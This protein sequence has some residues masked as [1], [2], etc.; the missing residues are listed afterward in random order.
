MKITNLTKR[1]SIAFGLAVALSTALVG[2]E[3]ATSDN[4][5]SSAAERPAE[6]T[7]Q[8]IPVTVSTKAGPHSAIEGNS[9]TAYCLYR[10]NGTG[11]LLNCGDSRIN[12]NSRVFLAMSEYN[13]DPTNTR[14]I[15]AARMTI[16]NISPHTN[17]VSAWVDV[18]WG[19][20][21]NIRLDLLVDP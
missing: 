6:L 15:G 2:Q 21:L 5:P 1:L 19:N 17:G 11:V 9:F 7:A 3:P 8:A 4:P 20:P 12:A 16:H 13:T 18:E 10:F 14:F